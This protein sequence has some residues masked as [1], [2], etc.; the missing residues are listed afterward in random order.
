MLGELKIQSHPIKFIHNFLLNELAFLHKP[1]TPQGMAK[2]RTGMQFVQ[3]KRA[4]ATLIS[5][6]EQDLAAEVLQ[7]APVYF[8]REYARKYKKIDDYSREVNNLFQE[9]V[10]EF[11][12]KRKDNK[13]SAIV[14]AIEGIASESK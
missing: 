12:L 7:V 6:E 10:T 4:L 5:K 2:G 1:T 8:E 14:K 13:F 9:C 11:K 3:R